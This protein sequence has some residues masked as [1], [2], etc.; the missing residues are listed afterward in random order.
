L[1][2]SGFAQVPK[3]GKATALPPGKVVS[4]NPKG[5]I[6]ALPNT[7]ER[8]SESDLAAA[9]KARD[10][11]MDQLI[12][13]RQQARAAAAKLPANKK[14]AAVA[15]ARPSEETKLKQIAEL[16]RQLLEKVREKTPVKSK[17]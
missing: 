6:L 16:Q 17:S 3:D 8:M 4:A 9:R 13:E 10:D 14:S 5:S 2:S 1:A 11:L 7:M 12:V 15:A